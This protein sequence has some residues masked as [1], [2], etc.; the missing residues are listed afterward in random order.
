MEQNSQP[1]LPSP[2]SG[3]SGLYQYAHDSGDSVRSWMDGAND[4]TRSC[5][6]KS[7]ADPAHQPLRTL[8]IGHGCSDSH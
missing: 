6:Y 1:G 3:E 8:R 7:F 5:S 2:A 4:N